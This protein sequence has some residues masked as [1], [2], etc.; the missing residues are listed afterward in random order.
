MFVT[1]SLLSVASVHVNRPLTLFKNVTMPSDFELLVGVLEQ[2]LLGLH[3]PSLSGVGVSSFS[4]S[5][6]TK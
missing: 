4:C 2:L 6:T 3:I 5:E 1:F